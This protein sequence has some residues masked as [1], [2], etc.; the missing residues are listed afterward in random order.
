[1]SA[2]TA[3]NGAGEMSAAERLMK[4]HEAEEAHK[5]HA[6]TV[7]D[8]PDEDMPPN[9][10]AAPSL[11]ISTD[12]SR[13]ATPSADPSMS[14]KAAG[15]QPLREEQS[16]AG[17]SKSN[18]DTKSEEAFPALGAPKTQAAA[19][20]TPWSKKP[21]A[22]GKA[23][24]GMSNGMANGAAASNIS[25][26]AST[27]MSGMVTPASAAPS[28]GGKMAMPG[29]NSE[30]IVLPI[31]M[32]TPPSQLKK[33]MRDVIR[34]VNKRSKANVEVRSGPVGHYTFEGTGPTNDVRQALKEVANQLCARQNLKVPVPASLRG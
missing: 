15:K 8:A 4:Q 33:P 16:T 25:S 23:A 27:P 6:A 29:R 9:P 34:D 32:M 2:E 26:R 22:V 18:L 14:A 19:A 21:A 20:P 10:S 24:N 17:A 28:Q 12:P 11:P 31:T 30:Q 1:M 7:E 13:V 5:A 3:A